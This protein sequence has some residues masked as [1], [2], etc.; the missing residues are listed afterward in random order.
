MKAWRLF[1]PGDMKLVDIPIPKVR[2][3]WVLIKVKMV[4]P[5]ITEVQWAQGNFLEIAPRMEKVLEV[6]KT[7]PV[8]G[9]EF[10]GTVVDIGEGVTG[11]KEGDRVFYWRRASCHKCRL[12]LTGYEKLCRKGP[13]LGIDIDGCFA[14]YVLLPAESLINIPDSITD[15][16]VTAMQ[17]LTGVIADINASGIDMGDTVVVFGQGVMGLNIMQVCRIC[18]AGKII[19]SDIRDSVL[20]L[21]LKLGADV[22]INA[23]KTDPVTSILDA[24]DGK[25][26]DIVFECAGGNKQQGL[27]GTE[28]LSQSIKV[29][30]DGGKIVQVANL[31][32]GS[33]M[34]I[35]PI[36][37]RGIQYQG[38]GSCTPKLLEYT[39]NLVASKRI[40]IA[41]SVTHLLDGIDKL[42]EAFEITGNKSKY[43][44]INPA[45]VKIS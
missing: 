34:E 33:A 3:G 45:Q 27:S 31:E 15:S 19:T 7:F 24:T 4:Q 37:M 30:R 16:E 42:G 10:C 41:A 38:H 5:S 2:P 1:S 9:H 8:F 28:T 43:S 29:V 23:N 11:L 14:E 20:D 12:C 39:I 6:K 26:A 40:K 44:A 13:I 22:V 17:P 35:M 32:S 18:G 25:G 36:S 21:S